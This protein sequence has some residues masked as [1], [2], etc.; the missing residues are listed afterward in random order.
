MNALGAMAERKAA[1]YLTKKGYTLLEANYTCR[2]GEIDLVLK[3]S[4][5][6]VFA[7]V[8]MRN[9]NSIARPREFVDLKKQKKIIAAAQMYLSVNPTNLQPRFDVIEVFSKNSKIKSVKHLENAF[10]LV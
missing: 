6:L 5:Y 10:D 1:N 2:F 4:K 3:N 7:E 9:E 8:K